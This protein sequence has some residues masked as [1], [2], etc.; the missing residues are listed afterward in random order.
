MFNYLLKEVKLRVVKA[1][2]VEKR[3]SRQKPQGELAAVLRE[4]IEKLLTR[5]VF[6]K[7][8]TVVPGKTEYDAGKAWLGW[9][10]EAT[11]PFSAKGYLLTNKLNSTRISY[12]DADRVAIVRQPLREVLSFEP[13]LTEPLHKGN[14]VRC[15]LQLPAGLDWKRV[16]SI[17]LEGQ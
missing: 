13:S 17:V 16:S 8:F 11:V 2:G 9:L 5:D 7:V 3:P 6:G 10:L 1:P 14:R 4:E 15:R 12:Q